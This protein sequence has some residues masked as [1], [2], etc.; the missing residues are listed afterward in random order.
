MAEANANSR[1]EAFCDGVFAIAMNLDAAT[2]GAVRDVLPA[3]RF[4][5]ARVGACPVKQV[6][7]LTF[8]R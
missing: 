1:L 5:P 7:R 6:V 8:S 2:I 3:W 4:S